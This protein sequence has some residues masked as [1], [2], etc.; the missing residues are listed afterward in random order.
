MGTRSLTYVFDQNSDP[1]VCMYRQFDGYPS[2]HG[3]ELADF[4]NSGEIVNGLPLGPKKKLFNGMG[5]LAAQMISHFKSE[6]GGFYLHTPT[7]G[8][9]DWQ[10]YE[11]HV[12]ENRVIVFSGCLSEGRVIFDGC[13]NNFADFCREEEIA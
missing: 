5:C 2:G 11:Y 10:D 12:S 6:S 7:L 3:I 9:D 13:W 8:R 4:L 1:I